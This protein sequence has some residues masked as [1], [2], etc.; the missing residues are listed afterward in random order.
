MCCHLM[1]LFNSAF[2]FMPAVNRRAF[3]FVA[4]FVSFRWTDRKFKNVFFSIND[5]IISL[6]EKKSSFLQKNDLIH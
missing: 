2:F 6:N 1:S 5:L 4:V 3:V